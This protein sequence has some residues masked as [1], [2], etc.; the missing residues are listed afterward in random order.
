[1]VD[2]VEET[3]RAAFADTYQ[4]GY[5]DGYAAGI[6]AALEKIQSLA[7]ENGVPMPSKEPSLEEHIAI[8]DLTVRVYNALYREGIIKIGGIYEFHNKKGL[9]AI[10]LFGKLGF[11]ELNEKLISL[12]YPTLG[13]FR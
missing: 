4:K 3:V 2:E 10:R 5:A 11:D 6:A 12:G 9:D 8:L 1:M 7:T 13:R